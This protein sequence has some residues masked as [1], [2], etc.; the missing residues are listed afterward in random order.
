MNLDST[1]WIDFYDEKLDSL[2]YPAERIINKEFDHCVFVNCNFS[3]TIFRDCRFFDCT[4]EKCNLGLADLEGCRF[5]N[6]FFT[7]S[8]LVGISWYKA[9]SLMGLEL[10]SCVINYGS[11]VGVDLKKAVI[12]KCIAKE[13]DFYESKLNKAKLNKT[14]FQGSRF[15]NTDLSEADFSDAIN[16]NIDPMFNKISKAI[17]SLPEANS[18]LRNLDIVLKD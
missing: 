7:E 16:Y 3:E 14:D 1:E 4:F 2:N 8:S 15:G 11:F 12:R 18:L 17:F 5:R 9:G 13:V 6:I 10:N